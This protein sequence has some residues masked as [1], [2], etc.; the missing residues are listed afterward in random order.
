[1]GV[2]EQ[3]ARL[4]IETPDETL[5]SGAMVESAKLKFLDTIAITVAGSRHPSTTISLEVARQMGGN[6]TCSIAGHADRTSSP[7]AGYVNAVAAHALEYD[8]Y[9]KSA[10]HMSVCLVPGSL[11][12]A[13]ELGLSG[14]AMLAGFAAGFEVEARLCHGLRP[15]LLDRGWHPNGVCGAVG[16]AVAAARMM[17]LDQMK[18]RMAIGIAASQASG[19]RKNVGSMGK[20]FHVGHGVRCGIFATLLAGGGFKVDPDIIEGDEGAGEGHDRFGMADTFNGIGN[21][22]LHLMVED[23]GESWEL[24]KNTTNVRLHP[25][26][27]PPQAA[28]DAMIDLA[29]EHDVDPDRVERIVL[30]TTPQCRIIACYPEATDSHKARFCLP[31]SMAVSLIDRRAGV[32]QYT[33]ERVNRPDVQGLMKRVEVA[34]PADLAHHKGQW[35][36]GGVNWAEARLAVHLNDGQVLKTA[37]SFAKGFTEN[38]ATWDDLAE[39]YRECAGGVLAP[40]QA[41]ETMAMI[42][43]LDSLG[44]VS[45]LMR[46]LQI[47]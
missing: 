28:I 40:S 24:V 37:R 9:T 30:E 25:G 26:S 19:V 47:A 43:E 39:K 7:L 13:E 27:T 14:R 35:G 45:E 15:Q 18:T 23:L 1:M 21:H 2:T 22:R 12:M 33:D 6:P 36:E 34:T 32:A 16:V 10:T 42:R 8:D 11:S 4:A 17:G 41:D 5:S 29:R 44:N 46:S 3:L 31:Y 38:P 20:A